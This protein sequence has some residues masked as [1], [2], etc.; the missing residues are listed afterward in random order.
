MAKLL[1][2][3]LRSGGEQQHQ[4]SPLDLQA[5]GKGV[6]AGAGQRQRCA[7]DALL[8]IDE[9]AGQREWY[10][11][12]LQQLIVPDRLDDLVLPLG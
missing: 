6:G 7:Q 2:L 1:S 4:V 11:L 9:P 5:I 8:A 10:S 12:M 3:L